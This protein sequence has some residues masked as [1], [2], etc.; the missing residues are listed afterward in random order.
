VSQKKGKLKGGEVENVTKK[1]RR[2]TGGVYGAASALFCLEK[3]K[4]TGGSK[5]R[6]ENLG[7]TLRVSR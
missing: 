2:G 6:K 3:R 1:E 7:N 5:L 4:V